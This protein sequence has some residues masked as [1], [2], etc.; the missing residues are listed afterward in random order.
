MRRDKCEKS[1]WIFNLINW[2][3]D[4]YS[5]SLSVTQF[6]FRTKVFSEI[7]Y[8]Y[9]VKSSIVEKSIYAKCIPFSIIKEKIVGWLNLRDSRLF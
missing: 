6:Y 1:K 4:D 7:I 2:F 5:K 9:D 8:R 3:N